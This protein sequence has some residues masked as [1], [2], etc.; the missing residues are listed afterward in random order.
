MIHETPVQDEHKEQL[1]ATR[2]LFGA[3]VGGQLIFSAVVLSVKDYSSAMIESTR[4]ANIFLAVALVFTVVC[5]LFA[6]R[7]YN[8]GILV[9]KDSLISLQ[10]KLNQYR[11]T[12]IV[13]LALCEGPAFLSM[14][15]FFLT[16]DY[17]LVG[18]LACMLIAIMMKT[19]TRRR[20]IRELELDSE[21]QQELG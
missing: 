1:R 8:N 2:L 10:D 3:I 17:I 7:L 12:L 5:F 18:V 21:E 19:P 11:A 6:R 16:G 9:A 13:Y 14:V 4:E 20:V 15:F